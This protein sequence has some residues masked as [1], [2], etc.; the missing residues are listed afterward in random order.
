MKKLIALMLAMVM[1]LSLVACGKPAENDNSANDNNTNTD[2]D[3]TA[4]RTFVMGVDAEYPPFSYLGED[5]QYTGFDVEVC[6]AVC[7]LLGWDLQVFG[8]NWDQ[9]LVQLDAKECDCVWS[10][11][12]IL[13]SMKE[14][15]YVISTPYYDNT[16]VIMVKEGSDIKSSAD[17]AGKVVAVQLGTSGEAL[18]ADGGD[19]ADLAATFAD[20]TTCDSF[21]KCFTELG[22]GAVDAVIVD[23]P[24]AVSYAESNKGF[25]VLDE[26]L[27][28]EQY[29]IAFRAGDEELCA[30]VEDAVAQLVANGTYDEIA[31]KYPDIANNLTL[32]G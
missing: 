9:K 10:G 30:T 29:G 23:K 27:G 19:L 16:Q 5:G 1:A 31:A 4:T 11:M 12:T 18:L 28:A 26:G 3:A 17:L 2:G 6:K 20:L 7:D 25:T 32:L 15:G 13:D 8:V 22:G 14:A 24:V 21:L